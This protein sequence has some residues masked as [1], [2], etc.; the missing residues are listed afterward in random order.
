MRVGC[1]PFPTDRF[2]C[3]LQEQPDHL[4]PKHSL[5][6]LLENPEATWDRMALTTHGRGEHAVR[7]DRWRY[8][9]Y[10]DGTEELYDHQTDPMEWKN[11]AGDPAHT[12]LK[13][14]M[15]TWMP[16]DEVPE[17]VGG[18]PRV[19]PGHVPELRPHALEP[20]THRGIAGEVEAATRRT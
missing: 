9:R 7:S 4:V 19:R 3:C 10:H 15:A 20:P 1:A 5:K 2:H 12:G 17:D 16:K 18:R 6:A 11:V 13:A 14:Q 8:I